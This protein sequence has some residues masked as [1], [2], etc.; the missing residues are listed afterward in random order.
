[1]LQ[2]HLFS[3]PMLK[4]WIF[5]AFSVEQNRWADVNQYT[6][7]TSLNYDDFVQNEALMMEMNGRARLLK[8]NYPLPDNFI[9]LMKT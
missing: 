8:T 1:M 6:K 4:N 9:A 3:S 5:R 2:G 7:Q